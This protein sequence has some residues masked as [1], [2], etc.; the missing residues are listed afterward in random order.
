MKLIPRLPGAFATE[1]GEIYAYAKYLIPAH[2]DGK[3]MCIYWRGRKYRVHR[4]VLEAFVGPCPPGME[5]CHNNGNPADNRLENLRWDTRSAN[6]LDAVQ[7]GTSPGLTSRYGESNPSAKLT[8]DQVQMI[9][10]AYADGAGT[11]K[12]FADMFGVAPSTIAMLLRGYNWPDAAPTTQP[13][14]PELTQAKKPPAMP[15]IRG[16]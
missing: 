14:Q 1:Q 2:S 7:H 3:Y 11:Q 6:C 5:C 12:D 15:S 8:L 13:S 10:V 16:E 9:R 4:L